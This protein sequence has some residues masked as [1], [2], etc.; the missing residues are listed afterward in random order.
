M[1]CLV[2]K[3]SGTKNTTKKTTTKKQNKKF[4]S[5]RPDNKSAKRR[6]N[7]AKLKNQSPYFKPN[8]FKSLQNC[9][10]NK[11]FFDEFTKKS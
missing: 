4:S 5:M 3:R 8:S 6:N 10:F 1:S 11:K 2:T 9:K 7:E